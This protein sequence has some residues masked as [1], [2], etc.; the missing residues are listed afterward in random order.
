[1]TSPEFDGEK[2]PVKSVF[3]VAARVGESPDFPGK[4]YITIRLRPVPDIAAPL[5]DFV[6]KWQDPLSSY[7]LFQRV[8]ESSLS[9]N[10]CEVKESRNKVVITT[11]FFGLS[12]EGPVVGADVR[13]TLTRAGD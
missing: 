9:G 1:M 12:A 6:V 10:G 3:P 11:T 2:A 5:K 8:S 4:L 7:S 13:I